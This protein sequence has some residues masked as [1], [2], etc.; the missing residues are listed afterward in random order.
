MFVCFVSFFS[1]CTDNSLSL[2][3]AYVGGD[4]FLGYYVFFFV[5][6]MICFLLLLPIPKISEISDGGEL[7]MPGGILGGLGRDGSTSCI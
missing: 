2:W 1:L 7:T 4:E 5:F 3:L 6:L